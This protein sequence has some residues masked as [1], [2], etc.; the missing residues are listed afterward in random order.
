MTSI[1]NTTVPTGVESGGIAVVG[2]DTDYDGDLR[3]GASGYTGAGTAPDMGADEFEGMPSYTCTTPNPG[4]TVAS[5]NLACYGET[6]NLSLENST[7]GTGVSYQWKES[8]DGSLYTDIDGATNSTYSFV[9][10]ESKYYQC[11]VTCINGPETVPSTPVFIDF[12]NNILSTTPDTLCG[13]GQA[14][15][16]ATATTGADIVWYD[17][18]TGGTLLYTGSPFTTPLISDTTSYYVSAETSSPVSTTVGTG[19]STTNYLP[20]NGYY[21]YSYGA[22]LYTADEINIRGYITK[23]QFHVGN[24][25]SSYETNDQI[26][27][28]GEVPYTEFA[29]NNL[30]DTST[31]T[32]VKGPFSYTWD[33]GGWKEFE[34]DVPFDYSGN[35]SLL[36]VW[37]N[38]DGSYAS[39]YPTFSY[40]TKT[41]TGLYKYQD[42]SYPSIP[43]TGTLTSNRPNIIVDGQSVCSSPRVEVV[44]IVN[45]STPI[46]ITDNK[47]ICNNA[48]DSIEVLTGASAY[49]TF[50]WSP[51]TNLYT[52]AACTTPYVSGS[53]IQKVYFKNNTAGTYEFVCLAENT[54]TDCAT[55]DTVEITVLPAT[56]SIIAI[57]E[58]I[59]LSGSS[60]L[61]ISPSDGYGDATFQWSSSSDGV[62]FTDITDAN[63]LSYTT[64]DINASTY[65][66]WTATV[67]GN[68]CLTDTVFIKVNNPQ[69]LSTNDSSRCG[70]GTVELSATASLQRLYN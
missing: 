38:N 28:M 41:N 2:I 56:V 68:S 67:S 52:D 55:T 43:G 65:Y 30:I 21:N 13:A 26:I 48:V 32:K 60:T 33:G 70:P 54:S 18:P 64:P 51:A 22:M 62:S 53:S 34:L 66:K 25:P 58:E 36:I 57:P 63:G 47:T 35:N 39:G 12:A 6:I 19:T 9:F 29:D 23:I 24:T 20:F 44:A 16:S 27:Y 4:N 46:T 37:V 61:S 45:P 42:G 49:E 50:T 7:P 59:C 11:E 15:L 1:L 14:T 40:T 17:V 8:T 3:F 5:N 10:T 31:L 69:I